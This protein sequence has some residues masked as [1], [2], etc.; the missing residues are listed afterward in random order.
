MI[1][2]TTKS[3]VVSLDVKVRAIAAVLVVSPEFIAPEATVIVGF[4]VS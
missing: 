4:V 2:P 1:S 3:V